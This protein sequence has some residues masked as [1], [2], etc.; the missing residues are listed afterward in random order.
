MQVL[1][2]RFLLIYL[3]IVGVITLVVLFLAHLDKQ[4]ELQR[5]DGVEKSHIEIAKSHIIQDVEGL[6]S[7]LRVIANLQLLRRFLNTGGPELREELE[8]FFL[9]FCKV[10]HRYDKIRYLDASGQEIIRINFNNG[11]PSIVPQ[12]KLQNKASRYFFQD[13]FGLNR[14]EIYV[15]PLDLNIEAGQVETPYKPTI[16]LGTPVFDSAG[17]KRGII[18]L[19]FLGDYLLTDFRNEIQAGNHGGML[20]NRDGFWLSNDHQAEEWGFMLDK[21][22]RRFGSDYP[23]EWHSISNSEAGSLHTEKGLFVYSTVRPLLLNQH[24]STGSDAVNGPSL[25]QLSPE[26]YYWKIVT[27]IPQATLSQAAFYNQPGKQVLL[28]V[29]YLSFALA[30]FIVANVTLNRK[31]A[32]QVL[33]QLRQDT[34]AAMLAKNEVLIKSCRELEIQRLKAETASRVKSEFLSNMSH[35]IRTPMNGVLGMLDI[36]RDTQMSREQADLVDTAANSAEA[37]LVIINN[38]LDFS[39]LEAGKI[40]LEYIKFN[41][42]SL[43]EE[44]CSLQAGLAHAK[45]LELICF[46]PVELDV[47]WKGDPTRIRQILI[48]LIG[49][50][51]KFTEQGEISV[52]VQAYQIQNVGTSLR[53]EVRDTG[54]GI[55]PETQAR[56]FQAFTQADSSTAR[57]FG[58]TGLG[59]SISKTLVELMGGAIG[60]ESQPGTGSCFWFNLP[61]QPVE[62]DQIAPPIINLAGKRA[63]LVDDNANNRAILEH[64]LNNWGIRVSS[65]DQA[66]T[67]LSLLQTAAQHQEAFD[68]LLLDLHMLDMDGLE[69][70]RQISQIPAI[71][72]TPRLL[73]SSGGLGSEAER[74]ALGI[75]QCLLKP[76]RQSQLFDAIANALSVAEQVPAAAPQT[77]TDVQNVHED[78]QDYSGK[79]ILVVEDNRINQK[80]VLAMLARFQLKPDLAENGQQALELLLNNKYDLV[81]MDCQMPVMG[82]YEATTILREREQAANN[83]RTPVIALTAHAT[84]EARETCLAAGMDDYLSKPISR[85]ELSE[86]LE[87]WLKPPA[88]VPSV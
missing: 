68:I 48:N 30:A 4:A 67:A 15:S 32:E 88:D 28:A 49:N 59:L 19:N 39:K 17:H 61:L 36:L 72:N 11:K 78:G 83:I 71:A 56:L 22:E 31:R 9:V 10:K 26:D 34:E 41:L 8:Q 55:S 5:I 23:D 53:F 82:G 21:S 75:Y 60:V 81:L 51:V 18:L 37:L 52:T 3:P 29:L 45:G 25:E 46:L 42:P 66:S 85:N 14:G 20:L 24:S 7:D 63:L 76:V 62:Q 43:V 84:P 70:A 54:I 1:L 38:I 50:A 2:Q 35:E 27:F 73:L 33:I 69:L 12:D 80:V 74:K 40:D 79:R 58:G 16:R 13:A 57:R 44:V 87:Q 77:N 65:T 47:Y 6:D 64:Y 86:I